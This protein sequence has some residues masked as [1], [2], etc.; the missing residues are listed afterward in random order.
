MHPSKQLCVDYQLNN[1]IAA[2][3]KDLS[4]PKKAHCQASLGLPDTTSSNAAVIHY[5]IAVQSAG[6]YFAAHNYF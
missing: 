4:L 2:T 3:R 1:F 5:P 6:Y